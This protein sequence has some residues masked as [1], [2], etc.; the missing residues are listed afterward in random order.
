MIHQMEHGCIWSA[1][2]SELPKLRNQLKQAVEANAYVL[3]SVYFDG[4]ARKLADV[5][6]KEIDKVAE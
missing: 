5:V 4:I 1:I 2:R 3:E 6:C